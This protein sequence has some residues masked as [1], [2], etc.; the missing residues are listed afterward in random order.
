MKLKFLGTADSAGIPVHNCY[1][2]ICEEHRIQKMQNLSTSAYI[3]TDSGVILLDAGLDSISD[4]FDGKKIQGVFLTHF[5]SDH[6]MGLLRLRHSNDEINCYHPEDKQGFS[7]LFKHTHAINY[8]IM[9]P[10]ESIEVDEV[11]FTAIPLKHSK[12]TF[13][14]FIQTRNTNIAYL[15]DCA[16]LEYA[17]LNYLCEQ[18][19]DIAFIDACYD[20]R[21]NAGNH[22][23]YRQAEKVL[24]KLGVKEGYLMHASHTTLEYINTQD[25]KLK[26][27]YITPDDEFN[28]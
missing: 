13:G 26:Y 25:V 15:T 11:K 16:G 5:H 9:K 8:E 22:L 2:E 23:N 7:D 12:N 24:D 3:Q 6:C 14:Y 28:L 21:K 20:E 17:S 18:K 27:H 1:C 19:I 10:F 4:M